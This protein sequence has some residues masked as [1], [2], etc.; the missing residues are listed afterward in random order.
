MKKMKQTKKDKRIEITMKV[1]VKQKKCPKCGSK[2]ISFILGSTC[3]KPINNNYWGMCAK[4]LHEWDTGITFLPAENLDKDICEMVE[5]ARKGDTIII[6]EPQRTITNITIQM[7]MLEARQKYL[8]AGFDT[9]WN[10]LHEK[11][12]AIAKALDKTLEQMSRLITIV[13]ALNSLQKIRGL[14]K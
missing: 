11:T 13:E 1:K 14:K 6:N 8:E 9:I 12:Q 2:N 10:E 7:E 4:C 3:Y 5:E